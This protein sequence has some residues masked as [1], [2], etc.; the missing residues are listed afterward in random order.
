MVSWLPKQPDVFLTFLG[1]WYTWWNMKGLTCNQ[2]SSPPL[3]GVWVS[4]SSRIYSCRSLVCDLRHGKWNTCSCVRIS[5]PW[6][7]CS[8]TWRGWTET[9]QPI[10]TRIEITIIVSLYYISHNKIISLFNKYAG[11]PGLKRLGPPYPHDCRK[12]KKWLLL[13]CMT[14]LTGFVWYFICRVVLQKLTLSTFVSYCF[15]ILS[16]FHNMQHLGIA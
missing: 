7:Q 2:I 6:N 16:T 13:R 10:M 12:Y 9:R 1:M 8:T 11:G 5:P 3:P 4:Q 14:A 15:T